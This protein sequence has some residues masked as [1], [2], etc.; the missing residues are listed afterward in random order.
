MTQDSKYAGIK[1]RGRQDFKRL[2]H[3]SPMSMVEPFV[4]KTR[5]GS[6]NLMDVDINV[7]KLESYVKEKQEQGYADMSIMYVLIAAYVRLVSQRPKVNRFIRGQRH[8]TR[9][10]VEVALTIKKEMTLESPDTVVKIVCM[11]DDTVFDVYNK[12]DKEIKEYRN[13][14]GGD[15]DKTAKV[16][17]HI[18]AL[19]MRWFIGFANFLDYLGIL[20]QKL[21][22]GRAHV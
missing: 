16:L 15:F 3:I 5:I 18:P 7:L 4:M 11:P 14:P 21:Q 1:P 2:K 17:A 6:M 20:P 22:I 13:S 9:K 8:W 19:F 12:L 10:S